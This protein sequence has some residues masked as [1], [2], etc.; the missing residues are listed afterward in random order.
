MIVK[1]ELPRL[2]GLKGSVQLVLLHLEHMFGVSALLL[3]IGVHLFQDV[4][5]IV[6]V[7]DLALGSCLPLHDLMAGQLSSSL[8][9]DGFFEALLLKRALPSLVHLSLDALCKLLFSELILPPVERLR[10]KVVVGLVDL[11]SVG[12]RLLLAQLGPFGLNLGDMVL[13]ALCLVIFPEYSAHGCV[14]APHGL[15]LRPLFRSLQFFLPLGCLYLALDR[16]L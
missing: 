11:L 10:F 5:P 2:E 12:E 14:F 7:L 8:D 1:S 4:N 16:F 6:L 15:K 13:E 9:L 3:S